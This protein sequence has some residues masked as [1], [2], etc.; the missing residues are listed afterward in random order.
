MGQACR[1]CTRPYSHAQL[2]LKFIN[3]HHRQI[4][5]AQA[6]LDLMAKPGEGPDFGMSNSNQVGSY[7][8]ITPCLSE[9][10]GVRN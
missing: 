8:Y 10:W 4:S 6:I 3:S 9:L 7:I 5:T 1:D 2:R